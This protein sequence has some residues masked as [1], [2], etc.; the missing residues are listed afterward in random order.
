M[1]L[2]CPPGKFSLF[3]D[4]TECLSCPANSICPGGPII[5]VDQ[6]FWRQSA[7]SSEIV[8]CLFGPACIGGDGLNNPA[9]G[10]Y[11]ECAPGYQGMLC[12]ECILN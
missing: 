5:D 1:C 10:G 2:I 8:E 12:H 3:E 4:S 6:G 7:E 11:I 9:D